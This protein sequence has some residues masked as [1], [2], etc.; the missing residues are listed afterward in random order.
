MIDFVPSVV[1]ELVPDTVHTRFEL[2]RP[3]IRIRDPETKQIT[4]S[5]DSNVPDLLYLDGMEPISLS[6]LF[7]DSSRS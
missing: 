5:I 2:Q 6:T 1:G 3:K 4:R 7:S